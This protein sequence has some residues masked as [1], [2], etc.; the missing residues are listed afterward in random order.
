MKNGWINEKNHV[1][2]K[3]E[4]KQQNVFRIIRYNANYLI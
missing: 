2:Q 1:A 3:R 4:I